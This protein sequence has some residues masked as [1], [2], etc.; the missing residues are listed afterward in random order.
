MVYLLN[1]I[2]F[3][4]N[5]Q[6]HVTCLH[7]DRNGDYQAKQNQPEGM[8]DLYR[9]ISPKCGVKRSGVWELQMTKATEL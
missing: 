1:K 3:D 6:N 9:M 4:Y 2:K 7:M 8:K 5:R